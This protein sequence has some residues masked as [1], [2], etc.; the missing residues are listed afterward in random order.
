M[1]NTPAAI[2]VPTPPAVRELTLEQ[3]RRL[4]ISWAKE[5]RHA[6][7][8]AALNEFQARYGHRT[9]IGF[10]SGYFDGSCGYA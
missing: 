7:Y 1:A 9:L 10:E 6:S 4:G 8:D 5:N 2:P 3:A